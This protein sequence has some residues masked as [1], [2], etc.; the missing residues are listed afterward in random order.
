ML[1]LQKKK[2]IGTVTGITYKEPSGSL[3]SNLKMLKLQHSQI[4]APNPHFSL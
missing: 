1:T 4:S 2:E 3:F